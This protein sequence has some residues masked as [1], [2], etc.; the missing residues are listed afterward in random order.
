MAITI[1]PMKV[2]VPLAIYE[3]AAELADDLRKFFRPL[4][5]QA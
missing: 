1:T 2:W 5:K 3:R 4:R